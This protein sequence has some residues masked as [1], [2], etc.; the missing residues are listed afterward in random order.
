MDDEPLESWA[1]GYLARQQERVGRLRAVPVVP[2]PARAVHVDPDKPRVIERWDGY[3]WLP[4]T[5]AENYAQAQQIL[6]PPPP[7]QEGPTAGGPVPSRGRGRHR[8][9][10]PGEDG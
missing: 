3:Q 4:Y 8:K 10:S 6:Y 2:G 7:R 5:V 9:P 1:Q